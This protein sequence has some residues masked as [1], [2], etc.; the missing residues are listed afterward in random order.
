MLDKNAIFFI[1]PKWIGRPFVGLGRFLAVDDEGFV[2]LIKIPVESGDSKKAKPKPLCGP[3]KVPLAEFLLQIEQGQVT[4]AQYSPPRLIAS[5]LSEAENREFEKNKAIICSL[6]LDDSIL[7]STEAMARLLRK[8]S[9]GNKVSERKIRRL[10]YTFYALGQTELSLIPQLNRRGGPGQ[11]QRAGTAKR[12]R[13]AASMALE[14]RDIPL[15]VV[16]KELRDGVE[17]HYLPGKNTFREAFVETLKEHFHREGADLK[18]KELNAILLPKEQLPTR[19]QYLYVIQ[20]MEKENKKRA[21]IPGRM[22]QPD[23]PE[24]IRGRATDGVLGPGHRFEIDATKLQVQ[25]VSRWSRTEVVG[26]AT[27]YIV[28]DVWSSA[29]VGYYFSLENASWRVAASALANTFSGK[30]QVFERLALDYSK[31][32]WPCHH[33]PSILMADRAE[34]LTDSSI[35]V[36]KVGMKVEIASSWCPEMKGTVE[37]KFSEIKK[38]HYRLPGSY[39]KDRQR[40]EK[41]GKDN[42]VLTIDEAE[43]ILVQAIIAINRQP[44]SSTRIPPEL[45]ESGVE[46]ISRIGLYTWGLKCKPGLTRTM[47]EDDYKYYLLSPG[48]ASIDHEGIRFRSHVFRPICSMLEILSMKENKVQVR[49]NEH[50]AQ[51]VYFFNRSS[52]AWEQAFNMNQNIMRRALAFYEWDLFRKKYETLEEAARMQN[53]HEVARNRDD[54]NG[55]IRIAKKEKKAQAAISKPSKSR[56]AIRQHKAEEKNAVRSDATHQLLPGSTPEPLK[57]IVIDAKPRPAT[58]SVAAIT[59]DLWEDE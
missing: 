58:K 43:R 7:F 53:A 47:S 20:T 23:E 35:G 21:A 16:R 13:R 9:E 17:K 11:E 15:P 28:V 6:D 57:P 29:I 51:S 56:R 19:W 25:L 41:D 26:N 50:N 18:S 4:P 45:F 38:A 3:V 33:L 42:A 10:L 24:E 2:A 12:G 37:S 8:A 32:D 36:P 48:T 52:G 30:W 40:G 34:L 54:A 55:I 44:V 27:L 14:G 59:A 49:Y 46:D 39:P 5:G 31:E 22:R 1:S